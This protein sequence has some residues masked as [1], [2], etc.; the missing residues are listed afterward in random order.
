MDHATGAVGR[1]EDPDKIGSRIMKNLLRNKIIWMPTVVVFFI[2]TTSLFLCSGDPRVGIDQFLGV[3]ETTAVNYE[4]RFFEIA[5]ATITFATGEG[6]Q[7]ICYIQAVTRTIEDKKTVYTITYDNIEG[8]E[9]KLSF[10]YKP[11]RGGAI[12]FKN[13]MDVEWTRDN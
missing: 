12:Q 1:K 8:A 3:W 2:L 13:Q 7:D 6:K 11:A 9:F 5:D 4:D 10:Y